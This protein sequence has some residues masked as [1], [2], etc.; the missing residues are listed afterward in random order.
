[1]KL[2]SA[3]H[4]LGKPSTTELQPYPKLCLLEGFYLYADGTHHS[5]LEIFTF[6]PPVIGW[7]E[8]PASVAALQGVWTPLCCLRGLAV[9][10]K[11][12]EGQLSS[13]PAVSAAAVTLPSRL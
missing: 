4:D 9:E 3:S 10:V 6:G 12:V 8:E 2:S 7:S 11:G 1:M 13:G 5:Q